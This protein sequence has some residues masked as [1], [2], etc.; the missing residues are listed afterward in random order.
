MEI[1]NESYEATAKPLTGED[2]ER[3]WAEIKAKYPFFVDHEQ[4]AEREIPVVAL[5][6]A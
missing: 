6:R 4:K 3:L 2:D 1:G 5:T